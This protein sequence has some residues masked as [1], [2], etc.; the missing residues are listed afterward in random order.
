VAHIWPCA[1]IPRGHLTTHI[2]T[3]GD[4]AACKKSTWRTLATWISGTYPNGHMYKSKWSF[5]HVYKSMWPFGH[6]YKST[7]PFG[8]VY[9]LHVPT[10]PYGSLTRGHVAMCNY[11]TWP[12]VFQLHPAMFSLRHVAIWPRG[13]SNRYCTHV[14][15]SNIFCGG[16]SEIT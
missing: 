8:H 4:M 9:L 16:S 11:Y 15:N 2:L 10:W 14:A 7:W 12:H 3:S 5:G 13:Y 1:Q 6:M